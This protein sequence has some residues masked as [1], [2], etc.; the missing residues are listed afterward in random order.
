MATIFTHIPTTCT[1]KWNI[2]LALCS[3]AS[4]GTKPITIYLFFFF[5]G[6][7]GVGKWKYIIATCWRLHITAV[8]VLLTVIAKYEQ[9]EGTYT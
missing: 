1:F 6:L 8:T 4:I 3:H 7:L 2:I 9:G 5:E